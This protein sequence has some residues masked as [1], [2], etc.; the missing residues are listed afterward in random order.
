MTDTR[1]AEPHGRLFHNLLHF[2]RLLRDVGLDAQAGRM[3]D[4]AEALSHV[5]VGRR[6]DFYH[7]L[8]TMLV[9]RS[10]DLPVFAYAFR[11]FWRPP[12][13]DNRSTPETRAG[14]DQSRLPP[15]EGGVP[16]SRPASDASERPDASAIRIEQVAA[17]S[18]G[19]GQVSRS[20][21]FAT[22]TDAEVAQARAM[23]AA[24]RWEM[25]TRTTRRW[26]AGPGRT[27]DIRRAVRQ[28]LR[29]GGELVTL[30]RRRR[31]TRTRPLVLLCDVSGSMA[32][33]SRILLHFVH[34]LAGG[35]D[36]VET[37]LFATTLTRVTTRLAFKSPGTSENPASPTSANW[38]TITGYRVVYR[39]TDGRSE[40][41]KDV[42]YAFEG[43]MT[44]T[45]LDIGTAEFTL[46]RTQAKLEQPLISLRNLG[47]SVAISVI[48]EITFF[49]HDQTG[50]A[51]SADGTIGINFADFP[52]SGT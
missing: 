26:Q 51:I 19:T 49:G 35:F 4:V 25:G 31:R 22:F 28:N 24:L 16:P 9:R 18:Y 8:Q 29:F 32:R 6:A 3:L 1:P 44:M 34:T 14:A 27:I 12:R 20:Q 48:A 40:Q 15:S 21:D 45:T 50:A 39:R 47:G 13:D 38:V 41:G 23:M 5:D 17:L 11:V 37:F 7:T 2:G 46:V 52:D 33:Y 30:P 36:H 42:P 43:G 10:Q